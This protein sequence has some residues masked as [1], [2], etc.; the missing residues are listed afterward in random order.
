MQD[1]KIFKGFFSYA[2]HDAET[3]PALVEAF[4][5]ALEKRVNAKLTNARFAIWRD[6]QGLRTGDKWSKKLEEE[7]RSSDILSDPSHSSMGRVGLLSKGSIRSSK[8]SKIRGV[9]ENTLLQFWHAQ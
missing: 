2:H 6:S 7:L 9:L 4:T 8:K 1:L 3:D 5:T